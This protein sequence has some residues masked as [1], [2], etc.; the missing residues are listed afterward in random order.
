MEL[1]LNQSI[2]GIWKSDKRLLLPLFLGRKTNHKSPVTPEVCI[3]S[4]TRK[5]VAKTSVQ[6]EE[7][8]CIQDQIAL[9]YG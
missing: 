4:L 2:R 3:G 8:S 7:Y 9:K 6:F 5:M 1:E